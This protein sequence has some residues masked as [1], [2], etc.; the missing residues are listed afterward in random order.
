LNIFTIRGAKRWNLWRWDNPEIRPFLYGADLE[1]IDLSGINL[2]NA[3]LTTSHLKDA[4]LID[5]NFHEA[6]L[7][8]AD[9]SNAK[10]MRA[11]FCRTDLYE[12]IMSGANLESANLQ[13]TQLAK[14]NFKGATL[15]NCRI[16]GISAWDLEID[17]RTRQRDLVIVYRARK[18]AW[19]AVGEGRVVV[20]DLR[21]AQ[22]VYLLLNNAEIRYAIETITSKVVLILGR[23]TEKRKPVLNGIRDVLRERRYVPVLARP[24][25]LA[26]IP[27]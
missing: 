8:G 23:F 19:N 18:D 12:T 22:F 25:R 17:E 16:Y 5:A 1:G 11:N 4:T 3:N 10:L 21:V 2:A 9:L 24:D 20:D 15:T 27:R 14:T 26:K 6:N 13:G 7:G